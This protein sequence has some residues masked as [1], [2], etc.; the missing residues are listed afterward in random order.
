MVLP[1]AS[2]A[3]IYNYVVA[4]DLIRID[5]EPELC[6]DALNVTRHAQCADSCVG[7]KNE[8]AQRYV[9][10]DSSVAISRFCIALMRFASYR[11]QARALE[12][13]ENL[14]HPTG[15][16]TMVSA[17]FA[18]LKLMFLSTGEDSGE[19]WTLIC[20]A[21]RAESPKLEGKEPSSSNSTQAW[22][23]PDLWDEPVSLLVQ[24]LES[25]AEGESM[26]FW[27]LFKDPV[28]DAAIGKADR[29]RAAGPAARDIMD[30]E[31]K[32]WLIDS[33]GAPRI[34]AWIAYT[35]KVA[36]GTK[37]PGTFAIAD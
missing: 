8:N 9:L 18:I 27:S 4:A 33:A 36:I 31:V 14:P 2:L 21:A 16:T 7:N 29:S 23:K 3:G 17:D 10:S 35:M 12:F 1:S 28:A 20:S 5:I 26:N 15:P 37:M 19:G 22:E 32:V 25:M 13:L 30:S 11:I 34:L 24:R 6:F